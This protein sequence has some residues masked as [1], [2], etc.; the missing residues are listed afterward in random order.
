MCVKRKLCWNWVQRGASQTECRNVCQQSCKRRRGDSWWGGREGGMGQKSA[1]MCRSVHLYP[2]QVFSA[3]LAGPL[4][5]NRHACLTPS[6]VSLPPPSVRLRPWVKWWL[7]TQHKATGW[8]LMDPPPSSQPCP[9]LLYTQIGVHTESRGSRTNTNA[10]EW[11]DLCR[12]ERIIVFTVVSPELLG[13]SRG[14][15]GLYNLLQILS[16]WN[17]R[18]PP[19]LNDKQLPWS[20][21]YF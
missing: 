8:R 15:T 2:E 12:K 16:E 1:T 20:N 17:Q 10:E 4:I 5:R 19:L 6:K 11:T 21:N 3:P 7:I 18:D 13:R 9:T 14:F